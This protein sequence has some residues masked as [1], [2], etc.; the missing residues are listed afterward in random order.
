VAGTGVLAHFFGDQVAQGFFHTFSGW[1]I[2]AF[3]FILLFT[4]GLLLNRLVRR[5]PPARATTDEVGPIAVGES[6]AVAGKDSQGA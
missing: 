2:F 1:L 4:E 3:A 6:F 5:R